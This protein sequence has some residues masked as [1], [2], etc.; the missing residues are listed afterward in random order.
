VA[1]EIQKVRE[2]RD[3]F[4]IDPR[5]AGVPPGISV[6]MYTMHNTYDCINCLDFSGDLLLVAAGTK[7]SYIQVWSLDGE[8]LVDLS[9]ENDEKPSNSKRLI[10]HSGPV[11]S[12]AFAPSTA[13]PSPDSVETK[14]RLLLSSSADAT[15]RLWSLDAWAC[16]V[17][18][19]GHDGPVWD[20]SW[21]AHG[22]YFLSSGS[23]R[24]ARVWSQEHISPVRMFVG[25]ENDV[26]CG[27]FH[28]NGS[29]VF[30]A[31]DKAIRMWDIMK[32]TCVRM[33]TGHTGN[34]TAIEC[35][36]NG[37]ILAS[38][39][40]SGAICL[41]DLAAGKQM[42]RM[43]GHGKGGI[44]SLS[45]SVESTVIV[46]GGADMTVRVWDVDHKPYDKSADT[47]PK[48]EGP[49]GLPTPGTAAPV[50]GTSKKSKKDVVVTP[51]QISVFPTKKSPVY[52]VV[53]TRTN[54]VLA[55]SAYLPD[56]SPS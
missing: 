11:F 37:K 29:Y 27:S 28:P 1:M 30:T 39:D 40:D 32:G 52:K 4:R 20:V 14:S 41:W 46:S 47:L 16:L 8:P 43:R 36:P 9:N 5:S 34:I 33:F 24:V 25:H 6:C 48:I 17:I 13:K 49:G 19:K 45:W 10:G 7:M 42:K 53:F 50:T 55:G 31:G 44:W 51:D 54:L 22:L 18:F 56:P 2:H 12:V 26:D 21:S 35:A 3:R 38:G 23:D 15:I